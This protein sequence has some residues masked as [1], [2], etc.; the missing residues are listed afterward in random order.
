MSSNRLVAVVRVLFLVLALLLTCQLLPVS[1]FLIAEG[2]PARA[3][4]LGYLGV[5]RYV[6][7][8]RGPLL[9]QQAVVVLA[10]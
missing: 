1:A 9:D 5:M 6:H 8:L 7:A 2:L 10:E 4:D 3:Q